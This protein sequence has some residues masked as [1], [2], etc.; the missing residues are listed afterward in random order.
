MP[1]FSLLEAELDDWIDPSLPK[2]YMLSKR[3]PSFPD[4][5]VFGDQ[6]TDI[7]DE[8]NITMLLPPWTPVMTPTGIWLKPT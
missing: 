3:P 6:F 7:D 5:F 4:D 1:Y 2:M 8:F